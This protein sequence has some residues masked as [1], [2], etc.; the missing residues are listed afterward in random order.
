MNLEFADFVPVFIARA[1]NSS[2]KFLALR[3]QQKAARKIDVLKSKQLLNNRLRM[4]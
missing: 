2:S 3:Y 1:A 4:K